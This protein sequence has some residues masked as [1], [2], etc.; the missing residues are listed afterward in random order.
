MAEVQ[1]EHPD[2]E[3]LIHPECGCSTSWMM[4]SSMYFDCKDAHIHSTGGM[5]DRARTS[6]SDE[7]LVATETGILYRMEKENPGKTFHAANEESVCEFMKIITL[8]KLYDAL[9]CDQ[10]EITVYD[11]LAERAKRPIDRMLE[12]G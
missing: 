3:V 12:L 4:R 6:E 5:L 11:E 7:F 8:E 10:F 2:A 1:I 9:R